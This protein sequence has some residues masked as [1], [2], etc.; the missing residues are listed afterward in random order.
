MINCIHF[1]IEKCVCGIVRWPLEVCVDAA[2]CV[3][4]AVGVVELHTAGE[5]KLMFTETQ[6]F[7]SL[8]WR[9]QPQT[10][11]RHTYSENNVWNLIL[12]K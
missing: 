1:A 7:K 10:L 5:A 8:F 2:E 11:H 6:F 3:G 4:V 9:N 12:V